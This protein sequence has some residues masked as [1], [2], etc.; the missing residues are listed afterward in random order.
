MNMY[1]MVKIPL[2]L[3][4]GQAAVFDDYHK[5]FYDEIEH[6]VGV[7][8]KKGKIVFYPYNQVD[9]RISFYSKSQ[10]L[11]FAE[12]IYARRMR[13]P[14]MHYYGYF[15]LM[16]R[17]YRLNEDSILIIFG[18][19]FHC[20]S[21]F[22]K[23]KTNNQ[24]RMRIEGAEQVKMDV[25]KENGNFY[26]RLIISCQR[27]KNVSKATDKKMGIDIGMKCPAVCYTEDSK[28]KF[29]GNGR[30]IR[31]HIRK[32]N[33]ILKKINVS[34]EVKMQKF[35][36]RLKNY[37]V[38]IDHKVS[39]DI[40]TFAKSQ[41]VTILVL[42]R[43]VNLQKKFYNHD[44][45]CW[46]YQRLQNFICYKAALAGVSVIFVDPRLTSKKCPRCGK[47]NNVKSRKYV[48]K[49]GFRMHRDIVGAMN[50]LHAPEV[51]K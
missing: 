6:I 43:L 5:V 24:Q 30:E 37:K 10:V 9:S 27:K 12:N 21:L 20:H 36:H 34:N 3:N 15:S 50:I 48:C 22:I 23:L 42:E 28:I 31:Y 7:Y 40:I 19:S 25:S 41:G 32:I 45:I 18:K 4:E 47:I 1:L 17:S 13:N 11:N 8:E 39:K 51:Q 2:F 26:A 33:E 49:C 35:N 16:P 38:Y 44:Q 29:I 46:S 14:N